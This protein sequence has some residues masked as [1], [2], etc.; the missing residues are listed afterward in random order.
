MGLFDSLD[1]NK[2]RQT[3][4]DGTKKV[5]DDVACGKVQ[6]VV[7]SGA[8]RVQDGVAN[9]KLDELATGA[10]DAGKKA[11]D[12]ANAAVSN[13]A[14]AGKDAFGKVLAGTGLVKQDVPKPP[15]RR[16]MVSLLWFLAHADG[17]VSDEEKTSISQIAPLLDEAY[18][19][20]AAELEETCAERLTNSAREF[21]ASNAAKVEAGRTIDAMDASGLNERLLCWNMLALAGSDGIDD[22][23]LDYVRYVSER[24]GVDHAIFEELVNYR[25]AIDEIAASKEGLKSA[26]RSYGEI[27]PLVSEFSAR[28]MKLVE[29]AQAL[30]SNR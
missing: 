14:T 6:Q 30:V 12:E 3:V 25:R 1:I 20:Y 23:E 27:E 11:L 9:V 17:S 26:N 5:Q 28:Q 19:S 4:V 13:A 21:G 16:D 8:K 24:T 7:E 22:A 10:F 2:V 29:A 18:G 15:D